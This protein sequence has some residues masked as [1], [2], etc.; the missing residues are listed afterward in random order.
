MGEILDKKDLR[1]RS[2]NG[3]KY[4]WIPQ[5][6]FDIANLDS[7]GT[8]ALEQGKHG[9]KITSWAENQPEDKN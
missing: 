3:T 6:W 1:T 5:D 2:I 4:V 9:I 8:I 7:G